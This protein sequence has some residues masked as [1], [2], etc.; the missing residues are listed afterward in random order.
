MGKNK[1]NPPN[2]SGN[3]QAHAKIKI[4]RKFILKAFQPFIRQFALTKTSRYTVD[5][6]LSK[7]C[8]LSIFCMLRVKI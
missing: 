7:S 1:H 6:V 2:P 4:R 5:H 8:S 3:A